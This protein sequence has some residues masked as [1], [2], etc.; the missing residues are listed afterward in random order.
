MLLL[1]E[2]TGSAALASASALGV[3]ATPLPGMQQPGSSPGA[4]AARGFAGQT[5]KACL[6]A[7]CRGL[8]YCFCLS[9]A[10]LSL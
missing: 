9:R 2:Q 4:C 1:L 5:S 3:P 8:A 6:N 7:C 10:G